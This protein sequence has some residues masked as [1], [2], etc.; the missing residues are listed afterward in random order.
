MSG[1]RAGTAKACTQQLTVTAY[2][3]QLQVV[4]VRCACTAMACTQQLTV[5][6]YVEQLRVVGVHALPRPV[7]NS[8]Q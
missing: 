5:T 8:L 1:R 6:T 4:G 7:H 3:E 2:V